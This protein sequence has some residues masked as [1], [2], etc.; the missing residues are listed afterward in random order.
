MRPI[1]TACFFSFCAVLLTA[2]E[3]FA[4]DPAWKSKPVAQWSEQDA[5]ELLAN[6][7][8]A[9]YIR[10]QRLHDLSPDQ[11]RDGGNLEAGA[12]K[13]VG[14]AGI[15][16]LGARR[17]AEALARLNARPAPDPVVV[18]WE[19]DPVRAAEL[20]ARE[21]APAANDAFYAVV[22]YGI[23]LPRRWNLAA[24]LKSVAYLKRNGKKD[25]KPS[26]VEIQRREDGL[27]TVVYL[28]RRSVEITRKDQ[29]VEFVAQLDRLFLA[30]FF[31]VEEMLFMGKLEL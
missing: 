26:R 20:R 25:L 31:N 9:K 4:E 23:S 5:K 22:V 27:A 18:R 24:E 16:L 15:G 12:G 21:A 13:G 2:R 1:R 19:S 28:F 8:W 6:S 30:Q 14:F 17:Q 11:R 7:P 29:R 10:P 3:P